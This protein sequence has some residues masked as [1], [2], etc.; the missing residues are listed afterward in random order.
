M[1]AVL[2]DG[3]SNMQESSASDP[4]STYMHLALKSAVQVMKNKV[5]SELHRTTYPSRSYCILTEFSNTIALFLPGV[6][7][8]MS[9]K[10]TVGITFFGAAKD[11][12]AAAA[13]YLW[14]FQPLQVHFVVEQ[15]CS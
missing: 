6:Q 15:H 9:C 5:C 8:I 3:R 14:E 11:E 4:S 10:H 12:E 7:V 1:R 2:I 13:Q